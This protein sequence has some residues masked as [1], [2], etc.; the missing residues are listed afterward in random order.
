MTKQLNIKPKKYCLAVKFCH[1]FTLLG[2]TAIGTGTHEATHGNITIAAF[3]DRR[4]I[5]ISQD[6]HRLSWQIIPSPYFPSSELHPGISTPLTRLSLPRLSRGGSSD[7]ASEI[8]PKLECIDGVCHRFISR[9]LSSLQDPAIFDRGNVSLVND[10]GPSLEII[11]RGR[12]ALSQIAITRSD[13][14]AT[15][16]PMPESVSPIFTADAS[17]ANIQTGDISISAPEGSRIDSY[18]IPL[19]R[20]RLLGF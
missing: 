9:D 19:S 6:N 17:S 3:P 10:R 5:P 18:L 14:S 16:F 11:A 8:Q 1:E 13:P 12:V 15:G 20:F 2:G 4:T 7:R